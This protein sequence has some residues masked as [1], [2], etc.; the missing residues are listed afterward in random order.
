MK[1]TPE[2]LKQ[3]EFSLKDGEYSLMLHGYLFTVKKDDIYNSWSFSCN[4]GLT[5]HS[6]NNVEELFTFAL[7][8][9][10]D[11]GFSGCKKEIRKF[12]GIGEIK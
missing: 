4:G 9:G 12:L 2:V 11:M 5:L 7:G 10:Y 8:D 3:M 1:I 6:V